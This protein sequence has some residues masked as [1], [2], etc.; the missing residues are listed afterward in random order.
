MYYSDEPFIN[1]E[2]LTVEL[3]QSYGVFRWNRIEGKITVYWNELNEVE[4]VEIR[5]QGQL[6]LAKKIGAL[7]N[8]TD[9]TSR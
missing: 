4:R 9:I 8:I 1:F 7:D 2:L 6:M 3:E 5:S